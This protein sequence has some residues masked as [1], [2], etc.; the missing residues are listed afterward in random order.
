MKFAPTALKDAVLVQMTPI[1]DERGCF[2]RTFCEREFAEAGLATRFVQANFSSSAKKGTIRGMHYQTR[3]HAEAKLVRCTKG[4]IYDVI[5]DL[6]PDSPTY[7]K[8]QG[9]HLS[10]DGHMQLYVP[11][12]FAHGFLTLTDDVSVAYLVSSFYAPGAE[13]GLRWNDPLLRVE[14]PRPV[15][16]VSEKDTNWP[17]FMPESR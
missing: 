3:P 17:D 14:W 9:F 4:A 5:M 12:G 6:R 15:A 11:E 16:V 7:L 13:R 10:E 1:A 8:A 2:A